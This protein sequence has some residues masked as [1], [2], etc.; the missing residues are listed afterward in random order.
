M[1]KSVIKNYTFDKVAKQITLTDVATV[2]LDKLALITD[3]TT[4]KIL[5]NFADSSVSTAT[6]SGSVITLSVLQGGENNTDKLRIDYDADT[7]DTAFG[8][9][10]EAVK[11]VTSALPAG[12]ATAA[13]QPALGTAGT[14]STDVITVQGISSMT[15]LKVD[16][17]GGTFP[18]T[19]TGLTSLASAINSS[20]VDVNIAS[21]NP[22]SITAN[23]GTNLNTSALALDATLTGGTAISI[24]KGGAKGAT[25]AALITSTAEGVDHQGLDVQIYHG[26]T[27]KDP[28]QIRTL[29]TSDAVTATT[30]ADANIAAGSAPSKALVAGAVYNSTEI[31]PTTGQ[32]FALQADAKGRLRNVIMDAAGNTR[33]ANVNSSNQLSVSVDNSPAVTVTSGAI[34]ATTN[35]DATAGG[36]AASKVLEVGG[37]TIDTSA[38]VQPIPLTQSGKAIIKASPKLSQASSS[39]TPVTG[40]TAIDAVAAPGV[41]NHLKIHRLQATNQST[42]ATMVYWIDSNA[43]STKL[44]PVFLPYGGSCSIRIEGAWELT[45]NKKLQIICGTS[46]ASVEWHVD[47]ETVLD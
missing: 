32:T 6:V 9:T 43:A 1:A 31:S 44:Y 29:T 12:A 47:Y 20:K 18:V 27:P 19:N 26:G 21:G 25:T 45:S 34:T 42:T 4:N 5:Y 28:T 16:G 41:G 8:D 38:K 35:A 37:L 10:T 46:G 7:G 14:A 2:R 13:K 39:A 3:V 33:G 15:A 36:S 23:A 22:T 30:N 11:V 40:N 17:T 24:A